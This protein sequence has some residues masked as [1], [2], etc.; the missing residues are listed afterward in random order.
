MTQLH[1]H[2]HV[3]VQ[4]RVQVQIQVQIQVL[5][6][7]MGRAEYGSVVVA[8]VLALRN[9]NHSFCGRCCTPCN[10]RMQRYPGPDKDY[11]VEPRKS[12]MH[13]C[14]MVDQT[15]MPIVVAAVAGAGAVAL[16]IHIHIVATHHVVAGADIGD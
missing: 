13:W 16:D 1:V 7:G 3:Q 15:E 6:A 9:C 11:L 5:I 2:V 4:V 8:M 12:Q 10:W 14:G